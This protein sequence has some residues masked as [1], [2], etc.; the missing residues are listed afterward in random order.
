V[1]LMLSTLAVLIPLSC[2][3]T[4]NAE[5]KFKPI[6][7]GK[8]LDGW[9]GNPNL[10]SVEDGAIT[11][12]TTD[13]DPIKANTFLVWKGTAA[14]FVLKLDFKTSKVGNSGVQYR[15]KVLDKEKFIVGGYQAD[16]DP[17]MKFAG[18]NYEEKGRGILA[19][20]GQRVVLSDD[21]D[22]K[23]EQFG[24]A[25]ELAKKIKQSDWNSYRIVANGRKLSHY[26]NGELMSE[27]VDNSKKKFAEK[28]VIALQL[29]RGPAMTIQFKN[30][31]LKEL[32]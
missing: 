9:E 32:K 24:K 8:T 15:S 21:E 27:V 23:V 16:I 10:W 2:V 30:L 13:D 18:I 5:E 7:D 26:I 6:F 14:N 12:V 25:D 4:L 1:R 17:S 22:P 3:S 11:G 28:G 19:T 20:R 29:H 31:T